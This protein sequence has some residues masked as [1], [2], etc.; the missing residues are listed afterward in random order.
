MKFNSLVHDGY[1]LVP[2][3]VEVRL[4]PGL[5]QIQ[6]I[7]L[8][9]QRIKESAQK[10]KCALKSQGFEFPKARQIFVNLRGLDGKKKSNGLDLAIVCGII[11]ETR[12]AKAPEF[13]SNFYVYGEI[14]LD[15]QV[16]CPDDLF[17]LNASHEK[18]KV[19]TGEVQN[20]DFANDLMFDL[21]CIGDL[22]DLRE[23]SQKQILSSNLNSLEKRFVRPD[24]A[25]NILFT[26]KEMR[27]ISVIALGGHSVILAGQAGVGK[28]TLA[29][30]VVFVKPEPTRQELSE[31]MRLAQREKRE[32]NWYPFISPHHSVTPIAMLGGGASVSVGELSRAH[33]GVLLLDEL[34]EF[35]PQVLESLREPMESGALRIARGTQV[36]ELPTKVQVIATTNL[37]PCG[38]LIPQTNENSC[39]I[40]MRRC[41]GYLQK[42]SGPVLD[43]FDLLVYLGRNSDAKKFTLTDVVASVEAGRAFFRESR[44]RAFLSA[45]AFADVQ[46]KAPP[47]FEYFDFSQMSPRRKIA[48]ERVAA[49]MAAL[50][51][52][53]DIE[54]RHLLEASRWTLESFSAL[55]TLTI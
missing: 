52:C 1:D 13:N 19:L 22:K 16:M 51:G 35:N 48:T 29:R 44:E 28:S 37:C 50:D 17:L 15:G 36:R 45:D 49:T 9:D 10:I 39:H 21:E 25:K 24:L 12:Q 2:V 23:S 27:L 30:N 43:R 55:K 31:A 41:R 20:Q 18:T 14:S 53:I 26:E 47:S 6:I 5:P 8:P 46:V 33:Q 38:D 11:W 42:L 3:E 54:H 40:S 4:L 32:L 34:L 7:G